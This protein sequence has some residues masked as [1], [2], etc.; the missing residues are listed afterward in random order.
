MSSANGA[1]PAPLLAIVQQWIA[2]LPP[3]QLAAWAAAEVDV[4]PSLLGRWPT[5]ARRFAV[6]WIGPEG[7]AW[8][9]RA[10]ETEW[11]AVVD[12][13]CAW[14]ADVAEIIW[15]HETWFHRQLAGARDVLVAVERG[16]AETV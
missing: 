1:V 4:V 10:G 2:G 15:P 6:G 14:R 9:R 7:M 3:G 16:A 13:L 11:R 12:A 5:W 8:L